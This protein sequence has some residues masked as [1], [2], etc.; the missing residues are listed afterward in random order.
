MITSKI[1]YEFLRQRVKISWRDVQ[2]GLEH[3]LIGPIVA[4]QLAAARCEADSAS[5]DEVELG[6]RLE[7]ES[8]CELVRRLA[9]A[10]IMT[11]EDIQTKWLYLVLAWLFENRALVNDPLGMVE[12]IYS[13]FG[14]PREMSSFVRYMPMVGPDLGSHSQNEARLYE[15]WEK[16]LDETGKRF[17]RT[18]QIQG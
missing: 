14:Y 11:E 12:E 13:D 17:S 9:D 4:I 18:C 16:F 6:G 2:F 8:I 10:E 1:S 3:Q 5:Q 7:S 15:R